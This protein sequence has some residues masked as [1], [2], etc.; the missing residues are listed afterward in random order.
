MSIGKLL[1]E[2]LA[3]K[4]EIT[5]GMVGWLSSQQS[6]TPLKEGVVKLFKLSYH[7]HKDFHYDSCLT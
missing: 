4:R 7:S 6:K 2:T 3:I 1:L 5:I